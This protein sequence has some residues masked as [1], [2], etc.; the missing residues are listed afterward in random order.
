MDKLSRKKKKEGSDDGK[1]FKVSKL[2]PQLRA[3]SVL[4]R[5]CLPQ[6]QKKLKKNETENNPSGSHHAIWKLA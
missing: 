6:K 5:L 3:F 4:H 2:V 1:V